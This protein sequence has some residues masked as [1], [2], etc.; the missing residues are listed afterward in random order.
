MF[1]A[2]VADEGALVFEGDDLIADGESESGAFSDR[3]SGEEGI[4]H[5][6]LDLS[7]D[8][9][10]VV[11]NP[12]LEV[13]LTDIGVGGND[14]RGMGLEGCVRVECIDAIAEEV[15]DDLVELAGKTG[16]R[17]MCAVVFMDLNRVI[18]RAMSLA[19]ISL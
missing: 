2:G 8:S 13:I 3:L 18:S 19:H 16:D 10:A 15:H 1:R 6:R 17:A 11:L 7:R 9:T 4:K 5:A 14:D 12:D